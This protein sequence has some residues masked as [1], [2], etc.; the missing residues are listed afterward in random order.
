[1]TPC[2]QFGNVW[3]FALGIVHIGTRDMF[4]GLTRSSRPQGVSD[5]VDPVEPQGVGERDDRPLGVHHRVSADVIADAEAGELQ[6]QAAEVTREDLQV[7]PQSSA[8]RSL[9]AGPVQQQ[10][11]SV[12][13]FVI[14]QHAGTGADLRRLAKCF[15][16]QG[17]GA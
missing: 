12:T 16:S 6:Y 13:G 15:R 2:R 9:R 11:Q 5:H 10:R 8:S 3:N 14:P 4:S 17:V 1:M 7:A